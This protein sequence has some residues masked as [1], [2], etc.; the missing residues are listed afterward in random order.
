MFVRSAWRSLSLPTGSPASKGW[1]ISCTIDLRI[2]SDTGQLN[3]P[4]V[5]N[6]I[7]PIYIP[8]GTRKSLIIPTI[9]SDN[10]VV[11][12][13]FAS[14][15]SECSDVCPPNSLPNNTVII[16]SNCTLL[17]TGANV[18]DWYAVALQVLNNELKKSFDFFYLD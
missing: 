9:D 18:G 14:T 8:V 15:A 3:T 11:R 10:D 5:S 1:S 16:S 13:R 17:I 6:M 12:C 7:S 4:P 2:R